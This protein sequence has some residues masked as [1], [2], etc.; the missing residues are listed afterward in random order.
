MDDIVSTTRELL[1]EKY[2]KWNIDAGDWIEIV[3]DLLEYIENLRCPA[4]GS[5][6]TSKE[7]Q[8]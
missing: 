4:C 1:K 3:E 8:Q 5:E 7:V 6:I 2:A